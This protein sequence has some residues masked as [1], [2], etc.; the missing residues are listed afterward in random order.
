MRS[1]Y[2]SLFTKVKEILKGDPFSG[3]MFLFVNRDRTSLKCLYYDGTGFVILSKRME[4]G[5]FSRINPLYEKEVVLT[6]AEFG[7]YF[8]GANLEKRFIDSPVEIR[9]E[10][11]KSVLKKM[12]LSARA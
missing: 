8:E 1:S 3:H 6:E 7:L 11:K 4:Q 9:R 10:I 2:D 5:R 12:E